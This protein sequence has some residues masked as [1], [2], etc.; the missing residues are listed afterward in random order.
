MNAAASPSSSTSSKATPAPTMSGSVPSVTDASVAVAAQAVAASGT[1]L[2][3][4]YILNGVMNII[5]VKCK[6][7]K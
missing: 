1:F 3:K 6:I 4:N 7:D 2:Y 5:I